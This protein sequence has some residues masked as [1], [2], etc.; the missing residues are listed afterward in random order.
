MIASPSPV[1]ETATLSS[2]AQ[3]PA[4]IS[5]ESPTRPRRWPIVPPVE[6][7]AASR[8]SRSRATA[9]T[10]PAAQP[11][12][13][14]ASTVALAVGDQP[15]RIAELDAVVGRERARRRAHEQ[16]VV[17]VA[18]HRAGGADRVAHALHAGHRADVAAR[19]L[20]HRRVELDPAVLGQ[21]GA[22]ARVE[23]RVVLEHD[24]RGLDRVER[25]AAGREHG[26]SR[27]P[28]PAAAP[29]RMRS[30]RSGSVGTRPA[31]PWTTI[32]ASA[33]W[34]RTIVRTRTTLVAWRPDALRE[35]CC[36]WPALA[37]AGG[38]R[39]PAR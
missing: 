25:A 22:A 39:G 1:Q 30:S 21:R 38:G 8:P 24:D 37:L 14:E 34:R 31:P 33:I 17:A 20:H 4:P 6:V 32:A 16:H 26:V 5:G 23:D 35:P 7:A 19:A 28:P 36:S 9:P 3:V 2:S 11:R 15:R 29:A 27:P 10:V 18:Q 12:S 13:P